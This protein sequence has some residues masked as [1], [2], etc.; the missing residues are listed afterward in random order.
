ML[1]FLVIG[2]ALYFLW[3]AGPPLTAKETVEA[4]QQAADNH[5]WDRLY[6]LTHPEFQQTQVEFE[7][8]IPLP[9]RTIYLKKEGRVWKVHSID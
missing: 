9:H 1:G 7:S 3:P 5:D 2:A 8:R 4:A 6:D